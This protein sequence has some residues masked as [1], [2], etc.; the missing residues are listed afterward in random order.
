MEIYCTTTQCWSGWPDNRPIFFSFFLIR[1]NHWHYN[2][3]GKV[4][5]PW[6][7][8]EIRSLWYPFDHHLSPPICRQLRAGRKLIN[9]P[10]GATRKYA[11]TLRSAIGRRTKVR[12]CCDQQRDN[13]V[14][15]TGFWWLSSWRLVMIAEWLRTSSRIAM[16]QTF[17]YYRSRRIRHDTNI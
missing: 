16:H 10:T 5:L 12:A 1:N 15:V 3:N 14:V 7:E 11:I 6:W 17:H 8:E 9:N 2:K 13:N 4:L